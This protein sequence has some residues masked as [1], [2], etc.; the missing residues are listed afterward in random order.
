[1]TETIGACYT[2]RCE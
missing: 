1:M 2:A